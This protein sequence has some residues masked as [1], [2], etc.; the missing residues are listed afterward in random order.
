MRLSKARK[1]KLAPEEPDQNERF[2]L[3]KSIDPLS[4]IA[5]ILAVLSSAWQLLGY[6]G[7]A[8]VDL[9]LPELVEIRASKAGWTI[10]NA[11]MSYVN[12]GR[13]EYSAVVEQEFVHLR[14]LGREPQ[15]QASR[16]VDLFWQYF[17]TTDYFARNELRTNEDAH[18]FV[19]PGAGSVSHQ[20]SFFPRSQYCN[21]CKPY[22]NYLSWSDLL[23]ELEQSD[24]LEFT[25]VAKIFN[26][27]TIKKFC[28][29]PVD[30]RMR[31]LMKKNR[32]HTRECRVS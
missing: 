7:G 12:T 8:Q 32:L 31:M 15:A 4:I 11:Q 14:V 2:R 21:E 9:I 13:A 20:T 26:G 29:M 19:A 25:F 28:V 18:P 6:L 27:E 22:A 17:I 1:T 24:R 16:S 5:L 30:D 23:H 3:D 10:V